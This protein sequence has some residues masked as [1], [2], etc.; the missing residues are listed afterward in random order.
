GNNHPVDG[1]DLLCKEPWGL[2]PTTY[3][4]QNC[5]EQALGLDRLLRDLRAILLLRCEFRLYDH[6]APIHMPG[7]IAATDL[8]IAAGCL[9]EKSDPSYEQ[10]H[11]SNVLLRS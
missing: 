4:N 5:Q 3:R 10:Y 9:V 7:G 6:C 8:A 1:P 11:S 2:S